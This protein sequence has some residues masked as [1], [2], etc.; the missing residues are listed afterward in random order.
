VYA[1]PRPTTRLAQLVTGWLGRSIDEAENAANIARP[2]IAGID[3]DEL[4]AEARTYGFHATLKPP[5]RLADRATVEEAEDAVARLAAE[6][7]P[8]EI[9]SLVVDLL[10]GFAAMRP[11]DGSQALDDL[12][13]AC[14]R[15]LDELR[16]PPEELELARRRRGRLSARQDDLLVKWGYPYVLD[17]FRYHMTLTRRLADREVDVVLAAAREWFAEVDGAPFAL[18][19]LCLVEQS[20][21]GEPFVVRSRHPLGTHEIAAGG[22]R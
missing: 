9:P 22:Q 12:A 18:D 15:D 3:I 5:F 2:T 10:A 6:R 7:E 8:I 14:V 16:R 20:A 1:A 11:G 19:E 21:V 4:T 17:E 13:A